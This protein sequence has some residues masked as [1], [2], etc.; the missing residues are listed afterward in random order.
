MGKYLTL[1]MFG[2]ELRDKYPGF[3]KTC[4]DRVEI[5]LF[6]R[7]KLSEKKLRRY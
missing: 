5:S 3:C 6:I 1:P 4:L 2:R 7:S